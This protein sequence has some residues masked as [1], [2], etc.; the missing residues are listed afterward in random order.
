MYEG[1]KKL[2]PK[3][4]ISDFENN[5]QVSS[6]M[7][8][9]LLL[10]MNEEFFIVKRELRGGGGGGVGENGAGDEDGNEVAEANEGTSS[11]STGSLSS[12]SVLHFEKNVA[13]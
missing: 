7:L 4:L 2:E 8:H 13:N 9:G 5:S 3:K 11:T 6:L 12:P 10:D 1:S